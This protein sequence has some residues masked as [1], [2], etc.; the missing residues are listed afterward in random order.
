MLDEFR[1]FLIRECKAE[2]NGKFLVAVSGGI[3]SLV[4]AHLF[5]KASLDFAIAHCNFGLRGKESDADEQFVRDMASHLGVPVFTK[6][7]NTRDH[8]SRYGISIQMAARDLRYA[9][10]GEIARAEDF[11]YISVGHNRND[12]VETMLLNLARGTG[13]RGLM[14]IRA[15]NGII[16]RPLLFASRERIK[17]YAGENNLIWREDSSNRQTKYT[18]NKI[19]HVVIPALE[20]INPAFIRTAVDTAA[21]M[22]STGRLLDLLLDQ[23]KKE[24][25]HESNGKITIQIN[26]LKEYPSNDIILFELLKDFGVSQLSGDMLL[27][28]LDTS[29][30]RQFH[31]RTHTLTRDRDVLIVTPNMVEESS[32]V[33]INPETA[34]IDHP[35]QMT[36]NY[37]DIKNDFQIPV[38]KNI[39]AVDADKL[40]F[41]LI[42]RTWKKGDRFQPLGMSG[43]KKV[44]DFL[45]N[46]KV[47]LPDK[48]NI[49]VIESKS[50]IVWIVNQRIDDRFKVSPETKRVLLIEYHE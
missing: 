16:I 10:F 28:T 3:D 48:K 27:N 38:Q 30:G 42:L 33:L 24:A 43:T 22:E 29:T 17:T 37:L 14:G 15:R 8:A 40:I 20:S 12:V 2:P 47:A 6:L 39:A 45:I 5:K 50:E 49:R 13:F 41:P 44:S 35:V 31:T 36:F 32:E 18:R 9:W 25:W 1:D 19:R 46:S 4:M 11:Q 34:M 26:R 21:R 7:F 23:I